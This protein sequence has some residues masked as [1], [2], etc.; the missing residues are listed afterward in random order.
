LLE[1]VLL[2]LEGQC[3][4][5]VHTDLPESEVLFLTKQPAYLIVNIPMSMLATQCMANLFLNPN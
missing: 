1:T 2:I 5:D 4:H 3:A